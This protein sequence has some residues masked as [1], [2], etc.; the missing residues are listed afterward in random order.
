MISEPFHNVIENLETI[1]GSSKVKIWAILS[2]V[3]QNQADIWHLVYTV[4]QFPELKTSLYLPSAL[5]ILALKFCSILYF[6]T[7]INSN[8]MFIELELNIAH[9]G[10]LFH[11]FHII[12]SAYSGT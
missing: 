5:N 6:L 12:L 7:D 9:G 1:S 3:P 11:H 4:I 8:Y 10:L 2:T